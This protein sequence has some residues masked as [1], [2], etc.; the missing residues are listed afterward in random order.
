MKIKID[1]NWVS[2]QCGVE[3]NTI[4]FLANNPDK[5]DTLELNTVGEVRGKY[6][7]K[8][9]L[10]IRRSLI[11]WLKSKENKGKSWNQ[12]C[13]E[14]GIHPATMRKHRDSIYRDVLLSEGE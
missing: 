14:L 3:V 7:K 10:D 12:C 2:K 4:T 6:R 11:E 9:S 8:K 13:K 5:T 1:I